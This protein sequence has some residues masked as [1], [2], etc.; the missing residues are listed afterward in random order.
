[1]RLFFL[2]YILFSFSINVFCSTEDYVHISSV[3]Y[4][5]KDCYKDF[6]SLEFKDNGLKPITDLDSLFLEKPFVW[7]KIVVNN[8]SETEYLELQLKIKACGFSIYQYYRKTIFPFGDS[9]V[10]RPFFSKQKLKYFQKWMIYVPAHS[11]KVFFV[12]C[13]DV[14]KQYISVNNVKI[15]SVCSA[16]EY[17]NYWIIVGFENAVFITVIVLSFLAYSLYKEKI[18]LYFIVYIFCYVLLFWGIHSVFGIFILKKYYN[19]NF[20]IRI[21]SP[22]SFI[23]YIC[24]LYD[25]LNLKYNVPVMY[26]YGFRYTKYIYIANQ[27]VFIVIS[28]FDLRVYNKFL[29]LNI[30]LASILFIV[31]IPFIFKR[32]NKYE[33]LFAIGLIVMYCF[34]FI[35]FYQVDFTYSSYDVPL[36][37]GVIIEIVIFLFALNYRPKL[38]VLEKDMLSDKNIKLENVYNQTNEKLLE[39]SLMSL[40]KYAVYNELTSKIE[41]SSIEQLSDTEKLQEL[42]KKISKNEYDQEIRDSFNTLFNQVHQVFIKKLKEY[43]PDLTKSEI[44]VC[45][46]LKMSMKTKEIAQLLSKSEHSIEMFRSRIRKKMQIPKNSAISVFLLNI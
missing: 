7:L 34:S 46:F 32:F 18:Y 26:K 13:Y 33:K 3:S 45:C 44:Q 10:Q 4:L 30:V 24:F 22:L 16:F 9:W 23:F 28:F 1:M 36:E 38:I 27:V 19:L 40:R 15:N 5:Q 17:K 21:V 8:S 6:K 31:V 25:A 37:I 14:V 35:R 41:E 12:K 11:K 39:A 42:I 20:A 2:V 29:Y 43:Y